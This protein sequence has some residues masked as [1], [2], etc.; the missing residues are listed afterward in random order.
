MN[1]TE[2]IKTLIS[3]FHN[4]LIASDWDLDETDV[5]LCKALKIKIP[6]DKGL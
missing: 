2:A 3:Y 5:E 4:R 1:K 6:K